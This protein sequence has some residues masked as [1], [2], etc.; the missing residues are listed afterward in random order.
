[1]FVVWLY[2]CKCMSEECDHRVLTQHTDTNPLPKNY[3]W[4]G[5][6]Y[7]E[8]FPDCSHVKDIEG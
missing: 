5:D 6:S 7:E 4:F 2:E 1:M 3:S 8:I